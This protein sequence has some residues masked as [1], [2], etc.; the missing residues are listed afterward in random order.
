MPSD[1]EAWFAELRSSLA[2]RYAQADEAQL[3]RTLIVS[4]PMKSGSLEN[5]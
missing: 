1:N 4:K 5:S 2:F 3:Q